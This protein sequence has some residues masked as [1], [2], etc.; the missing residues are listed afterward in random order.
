MLRVEDL[1]NVEVEHLGTKAR[2]IAPVGEFTPNSGKAPSDLVAV[3]EKHG[4]IARNRE[5][6]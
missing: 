1:D 3:P 5:P 2:R 4:R 6:V